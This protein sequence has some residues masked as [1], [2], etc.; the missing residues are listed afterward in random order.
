MVHFRFQDGMIPKRLTSAFLI[1]FVSILI[2][3]EKDDPGLNPVYGDAVTRQFGDVPALVQE[4][5]FNSGGFHIVGDFRTPTEGE[6]F[7]AIIMVHGSGSA[8]R[9]GAVYFRPLIEIFLRNGYAVLSWDKPGSG[10]STGSFTQGYTVTERANI[11]TDAVEV[12]TQNESILNTFIGTWGISQ[13]GWVMPKAHEKTDDI[14]FMIVA[15]GGAED[16]IEQMAYQVSQIVACGGGTAEQVADVE[17]YWSQMQ[18]AREYSEY[19]EAADILVNIPGVSENTGL[20]VSTQDQWN[21]WPLEI[22]AFWDP[23]DVI[24]KTTIPMLVHFGELDKNI[25][26]VQ[27]AQAY[28]AALNKAGN[29]DFMIITIGG[30]GHVLTPATT[31]CL[32]EPVNPSWVGEYL[33][34]LDVW[35]G[36]RYPLK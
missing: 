4:L 23:M 8:T 11:L 25:D 18:K 17:K 31:G 16:G 30:A 14:A 19:K 6:L 13:A 21:P 34:T 20:S 9:E 15:S 12:L 27:G 33:D 3:C 2:S 35:V 7:P 29:N 36:N 24:E 26:P 22:D 10:K 28:E 5:S 32:N 1:L